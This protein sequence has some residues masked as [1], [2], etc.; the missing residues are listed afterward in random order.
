MSEGKKD[1]FLTT[2]SSDEVNKL[3]R[4]LLAEF[5]RI[6]ICVMNLHDGYEL[7]VMNNWGGLLPK[8]EDAK[9]RAFV[10]KK[11]RKKKSE[12]PEKPEK[13]GKKKDITEN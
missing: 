7:I 13:P 2:K 8:E 11:T 10:N 6:W 4:E 12:K 1:V 5:P 9:V 3:R